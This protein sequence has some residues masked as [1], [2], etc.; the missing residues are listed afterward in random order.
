[1]LGLLNNVFE[2]LPGSFDMFSQC[3]AIE[4]VYGR[5]PVEHHEIHLQLQGNITHLFKPVDSIHGASKLSVV[6][7]GCI[8][9][10]PDERN[11]RKQVI[12]I[13]LW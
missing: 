10:S 5:S 2:P 8:N 7:F 9:S 1:M 4:L 3:R 13:I 11:I 6:D 12:F